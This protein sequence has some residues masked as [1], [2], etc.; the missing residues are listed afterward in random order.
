[1]GRPSAGLAGFAGSGRSTS[2]ATPSR[3]VGPQLTARSTAPAVSCRAVIWPGGLEAK[4]LYRWGPAPTRHAG[5]SFRSCRGQR[6]APPSQGTS[7]FSRASGR[8]TPTPRVLFS[9]G[10]FLL[11]VHRVPDQRTQGCDI[12]TLNKKAPPTLVSCRALAQAAHFPRSS[13]GKGPAR[14]AP[15]PAPVPFRPRHKRLCAFSLTR[16]VVSSRSV[17]SFSFA[18]VTGVSRRRS[19]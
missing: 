14:T 10:Y 5:P 7:W 9:P 3:D 13:A 17:L 1:M 19:C 8:A 6:A 16:S 15:Q 11:H 4:R 18:P 12:P 2:T